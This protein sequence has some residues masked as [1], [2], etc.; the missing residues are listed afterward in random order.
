MVKEVKMTLQR[1]IK[2]IHQS[3]ERL[4]KALELTKDRYRWVFMR[5]ETWIHLKRTL[6]LLW[7]VLRRKE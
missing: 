4:M 5:R 1:K 3:S 6:E 2:L 7:L